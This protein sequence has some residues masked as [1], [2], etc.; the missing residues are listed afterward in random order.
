MSE[1]PNTRKNRQMVMDAICH[2]YEISEDRL[3]TRTRV[4]EVV[5][6][7]QMYYKV[8]REYLG[9]TY[10]A[11]AASL[12]NE[13]KPYD[14]TTVM[15]SIRLLNDLISIGDK[16]VILNH[17][18]VMDYIK[19]HGDIVKT[20]EIKLGADQAARIMNYL[21]SEGLVFKVRQ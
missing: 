3:C 21:N 10:T 1:A 13:H 19:D 20:I 8:A 4:R 7:R 2:V 16:E 14:H 12:R 15:H 6:A 9:M 18:S 5:S 17:S 11:I